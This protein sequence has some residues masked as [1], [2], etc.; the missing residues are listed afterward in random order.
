MV[1]KGSDDKEDWVQE[2]WSIN[3]LLLELILSLKGGSFTVA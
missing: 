1:A 2:G 3:V